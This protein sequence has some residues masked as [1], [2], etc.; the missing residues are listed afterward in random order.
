[1]ADKR[2]IRVDWYADNWLGG[3]VLLSAEERGIY[4]TMINLIY[5]TN[6]SLEDDDVAMAHA[7]N[8]G[9][10]AYRRAKKRLLELDKI[11]C[12]EGRIFQAKCAKELTRASDRI[13]A[14]AER[15]M[16]K[17][18]K[19]NDKKTSK[20]S[21]KL[22]GKVVTF[23]G[24]H[25]P[26]I[27][28]T[29]SQQAVSPSYVRA[30]KPVAGGKNSEDEKPSAHV[31]AD[32]ALSPTSGQGLSAD[33]AAI[34]R[35][36]SRQ[37]TL[38]PTVSLRDVDQIR[39]AMISLEGTTFTVGKHGVNEVAFRAVQAEAEAFG[40]QLQVKSAAVVQLVTGGQ[41]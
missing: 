41:S 20:K 27:E 31:A 7:C 29:N 18:L 4:D 13:D 14:Y 16:K 6:T 39:R 12:R 24:N 10:A 9:R 40:Y 32:S 3:V 11:E 26:S 33:D 36:V 5:Q 35:E 37:A 28:R 22:E 21:S 34:W 15:E 23:Q 25:T 2:V 17:K 1:M 19:E 8:C 30:N 38:R